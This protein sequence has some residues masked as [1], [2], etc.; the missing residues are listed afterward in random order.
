MYNPKLN[1]ILYGSDSAT[2][3]PLSLK[4]GHFD[5]IFQNGMIR[6]I[7]FD[8]IP[9]CNR[10]YFALRDRHWNTVPGTFTI[11]RQTS[12]STGF[13]LA[14]KGVYSQ[15]DITLESSFDLHGKS[16]GDITFSFKAVACTSF[17][18]NRIGFCTLL[19]VD[20]CI[21]KQYRVIQSDN[22]VMHSTFPE[23]IV[24][25]QPNLDIKSITHPISDF[26][27]VTI[28]FDGDLFEMEDQRNWT[29]YSYKIYSTRLS[30]PLPVLVEKG[31]TIEQKVTFTVAPIST[32]T[33]SPNQK[34]RSTPALHNIS[35]ETLRKVPQIGTCL[36]YKKPHTI[37]LDDI[38]SFS[39]I[40]FDIYF[41]HQN[42]PDLFSSMI[43][44][45]K[46]LSITPEFVLFCTLNIHEELAIF[47]D[48]IAVS[49]IK[50]A[51]IIVHKQ[52][53]NIVSESTITVTK[54]LLC[55]AFPDTT[56]LFG[57]DRYFVE[58]NRNRNSID[59]CEQFCYSLNP[60]VHTFDN[61]SIMEN[62]PGITATIQ[63]AQTLFGNKKVHITPIT[64]R[65]RINRSNQ[66]KSGGPDMRLYGLFGAAWTAGALFYSIHDNV[67][68]LCFFEL[69][70]DHGIF[71]NI[72]N[73][74][75]PAYHL[76]SKVA[77]F[78]G[79]YFSMMRSGN[80]KSIV[81]FHLQ[82]D[83]RSLQVI[84]NLT[85][86]I[87]TLKIT[88]Q[89]SGKAQIIDTM[90]Y[91]QL[92]TNYKKWK[93]QSQQVTYTDAVILSEYAVILIERDS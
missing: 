26:S 81:A 88:N 77:T 31:T 67:D 91:E 47:A 85:N 9:V 60:Q 62:L 51:R 39:Y 46:S 37:D 16:S 82:K 58:L 8:T 50:P 24:P 34:N 35:S 89:I 57:T 61:E 64:L 83:N 72:R 93:K 14:F 40:R 65:P 54:A 41:D 28:T 13:D 15:G 4:A 7:E 22:K 32:T 55:Q 18:R 3:E 38:C 56:I 90:S 10:V 6:Q 59:L 84:A 44:L 1:T 53:E 2:S 80:P 63:T 33:I 48:A 43:S 92:C 71:D 79:G 73:T 66:L 70:G 30:D 69:N 87:Q 52:N 20:Q 23:M 68:S 17:Y 12:D 21:G 45:C 27:N 49:D 19:P 29:D 11:I 5:L 76:L 36:D 25:W 74:V 75:T 42:Y 78:S 86:T